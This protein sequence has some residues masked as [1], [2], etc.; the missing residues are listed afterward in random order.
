MDTQRPWVRV[1][2]RVDWKLILTL[3]ILG[4]VT[5]LLIK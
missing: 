1:S 5:W 2:V 4:V 3:A